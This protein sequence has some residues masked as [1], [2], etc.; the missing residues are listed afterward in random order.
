M[1]RMSHEIEAKFRVQRFGPI[2]RRLKEAGAEYLCTVRQSDTY[3]DTA[4]RMLRGRD[5]GL[6]IRMFRCLRRGAEL[7][8]AAGDGR[9]LQGVSQRWRAARHVAAGFAANSREHS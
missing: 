6:R 2:R 9:H 7:R 4:E 8:G 5:C 1:P 3:Y